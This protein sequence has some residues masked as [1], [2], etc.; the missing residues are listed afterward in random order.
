M[1][2]IFSCIGRWILAPTDRDSGLLKF[3]KDQT[4]KEKIIEHESCSGKRKTF[5]ETKQDFKGLN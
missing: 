1:S 5:L 3:C 2:S 4:K